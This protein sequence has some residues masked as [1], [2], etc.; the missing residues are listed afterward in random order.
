MTDEQRNSV[1]GEASAPGAVLRTFSSLT[2]RVAST[3]LAIRVALSI[4]LLLC[5]GLL[6]AATGFEISF[7]VFYLAPV[8]LA[9]ATVSPSPCGWRTT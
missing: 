6:D 5:V 2:S 1:P 9:G 4:V 3:P 8:L 7:S